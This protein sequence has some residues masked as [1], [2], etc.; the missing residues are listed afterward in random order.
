MQTLIIV[1]G[2]V[3]YK[4]KYLLLKRSPQNYSGGDWEFV[5]GF[6]KE[7]ELAEFAVLRELQEETG[8][9]GTIIKPLSP[10]EVMGRKYRYVVIPYLVEVHSRI[11]VLSD[12]HTEYV[13]T[14]KK[15]LPTYKG[16]IMAII[17]LL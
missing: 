7:K 2:V 9:T 14:T 3:Q 12:E 17:N 4:N 6:I 10:V 5:M 15:E 11:I 13:W 8:L 16:I 1:A